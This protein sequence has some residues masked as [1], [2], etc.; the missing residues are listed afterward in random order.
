MP[1]LLLLFSPNLI[2]VVYTVLYLVFMSER[3]C[4]CEMFYYRNAVLILQTT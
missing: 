2:S 3:S 4:D 1:L